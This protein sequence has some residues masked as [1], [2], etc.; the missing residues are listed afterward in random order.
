MVGRVSAFSHASPQPPAT[1]WRIA[2]EALPKSF[3]QINFKVAVRPSH[4]RPIRSSP[5]A[6]AASAPAAGKSYRAPFIRWII[7]KKVKVLFFAADP[8]SVGEG[9]SQRLQLDAEV[10]EIEERVRASEHGDAVEFIYRLAARPKDVLQALNEL[11]PD[12]VHFSGHGWSEGLFLMDSRDQ[13]PHRMDRA[14]LG[15]LFQMFRGKIRVVVLNACFSDAQAEAVA[16]EVGCAIGMSGKISDD[17]AIAF[18]AAFY[19]AIGFGKSVKTAFGQGRFA[20]PSGEHERPRLVVRPGTDAG[21]VFVVKPNRGRRFAAGLAVAAVPAAILVHEVV[22]D[23]FAACAWAGVVPAQA[24]SATAEIQSDLDRAKLDYE[25]G[26]YAVAFP[27]FRRL[28]ESGNPEA[29]RFVGAMYLRGQGTAERPDSGIHWLREAA[30]QRDP[31]A[32]T[33]LGSAYQNGEGVN[34]NLRWARD[35]YHK[36]VDEKKSPEAMRRLGVLSRS[37]QNDSAALGWF[38]DAAKAGSLEARI[39]AGQLYEEGQGTPRDPEVARCLYHTA[40]EG[41]S[42][43]GMLIMARIYRDG[44]GVSRDYEKAADWYGRAAKR[45]SPDA[46]YALGELFRDGLGVPRDTARSAA[47][48]ASARAAR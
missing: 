26:R 7:M 13:R 9:R 14:V 4:T 10:R 1:V 35:W 37:E 27:R 45:G 41:G 16:R 23:P 32:M 8:H 29:M 15:E 11:Q 6:M 5:A 25:A 39:D 38:R 17:A 47:W 44:I 19:G 43:R 22:K 24:A 30:Y 2:P 48:F 31:H 3:V 40:A 33:M 42:P 28:A 12:I 20:L 21:K 34:R 18:G 36:A 46:M